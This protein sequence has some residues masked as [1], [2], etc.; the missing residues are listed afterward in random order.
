VP[1]GPEIKHAS[2]KLAEA[3]R[4]SVRGTC[5]LGFQR[6]RIT[7]P[8]SRAPR[9]CVCRRARRPCWSTLTV[10]SLCT[11]TTSST[12]AGTPAPRNAP[13]RPAAS[14]VSPCTPTSAGR[15]STALRRSPSFPRQRS[16]SIRTSPSSGRT[17]STN[18]SRLRSSNAATAMIALADARWAHFCSTRVSSPTSAITCAA[19]SCSTPASTPLPGPATSRPSRSPLLRR[20]SAF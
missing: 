9:C 6:T 1:E 4:A 8:S 14:L 16:S 20:R 2:D 19:R 11:A 12:A 10:T 13:Q 3:C 15:C 5:S 17:C 7:R 18:A